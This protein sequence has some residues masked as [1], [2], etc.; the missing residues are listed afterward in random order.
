MRFLVS[1][2]KNKTIYNEL[3][4]CYKSR[5]I[6][7]FSIELNGDKERLDMWSNYLKKEMAMSLESSILFIINSFKVSRVEKGNCYLYLEDNSKAD[8]IAKLITYGNNEIKGISLIPDI[9]EKQLW[10]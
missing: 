9:V 7:M 5:L 8:K 6:Q 4:T 3:K 1:G 2:I 10:L